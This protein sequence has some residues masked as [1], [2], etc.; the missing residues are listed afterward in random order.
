MFLEGWATR[1]LL[2]TEGLQQR[3]NGSHESPR[4]VGTRAGARPQASWLPGQPSSCPST[5]PH[6]SSTACQRQTPEPC[7]AK[8]LQ[9]VMSFLR[10]DP[11]S[12]RWKSVWQAR[13]GLS[14][15]TK[16]LVFFFFSPPHICF[17]QSCCRRAP[18][19]SSKL[20][21]RLLSS[22]HQQ[23]KDSLQLNQPQPLWPRANHL[24]ML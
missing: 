14:P 13:Q 19:P 17:V 8:R 5:G 15:V 20:H 11:G 12:G 24:P 7:P 10:W 21:T 3:K 9:V 23:I 2:Q 18:G 16:T 22:H 1:L 4:Q 6:A